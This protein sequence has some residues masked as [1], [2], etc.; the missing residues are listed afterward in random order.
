MASPSLASTI[1]SQRRSE[2]A[3]DFTIGSS[4]L[5]TGH[6]G[7]TKNTSVERGEGVPRLTARPSRSVS[8]NTG[9]LAPTAGPVSII[10][11]PSGETR[12]Y[13]TPIWRAS[14]KTTKASATTATHS[15]RFETMRMSVMA[16]SRVR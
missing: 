16:A 12:S 6:V 15:T 7:E 3:A 4:F 9:A 14:A 5:Q 11:A 1:E 10:S 2:A 13:S 8:A